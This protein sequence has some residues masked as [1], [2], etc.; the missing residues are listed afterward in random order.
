M[1]V[2]EK[3]PSLEKTYLVMNVQG[4][5]KE[6]DP[7]TGKPTGKYYIALQLLDETSLPQTGGVKAVTFNLHQDDYKAL[8]EP[9]P[10]QKV[11]IVA[12]VLP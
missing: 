3:P 5:A 10:P 12:T 1:S 2:E 6:V 4:Q 9:R 7:A 11:K 8:G